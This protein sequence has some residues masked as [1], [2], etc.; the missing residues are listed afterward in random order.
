MD[1]STPRAP[2]AHNLGRGA[3]GVCTFFLAVG[4]FTVGTS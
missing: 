1:A 4:P 2:A 3:A